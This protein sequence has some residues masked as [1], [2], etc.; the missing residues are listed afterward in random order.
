MAAKADTVNNFI[1]DLVCYDDG[2]AVCGWVA[3]GFVKLR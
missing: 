2:E 3:D 1:F